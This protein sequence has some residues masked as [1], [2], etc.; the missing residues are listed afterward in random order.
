MDRLVHGCLFVEQRQQFAEL[1]RAVLE[2]DHA[3]HLAIADAEAGQQVDRAVAL[4]LELTPRWPRFGWR[5]TWHWRLVGRGR[6]AN[7][8]ARLLVD[9]EQRPVGG[10]V[11]EQFDDGHRFGGEVGITIVHPGLKDGPGEP[12]AA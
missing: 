9:T 2:A 3:T 10:R 1:A 7:A 11:Q 12:G 5:P 4:V 8:N 6:L